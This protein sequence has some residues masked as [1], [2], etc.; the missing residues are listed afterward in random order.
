[1]TPNDITLSSQGTSEPLREP[2]TTR[3]NNISILELRSLLH[4]LKD[5]RPDICVRIR[6]MGEMWQS[7]YF[8][9]VKV[10]ELGVIL[11]IESGDKL[12]NVPDLKLIMQIEIDNAFMHH[13]PN[14][15]YSV[16]L[17]ANP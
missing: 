14:F 6:L 5:R 9:I 7:S 12:I 13:Q 11:N 4:Q 15:H 17:D 10:T 8:R 2:S 3:S 1:M 16:T